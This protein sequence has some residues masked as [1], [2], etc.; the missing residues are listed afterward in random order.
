MAMIV[1]AYQFSFTGTMFFPSYF[2]VAL[3]ASAFIDYTSFLF[4]F[5]FYSFFLAWGGGG[6]GPYIR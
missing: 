1:D 5:L 4:Y 3:G 2:C 6:G